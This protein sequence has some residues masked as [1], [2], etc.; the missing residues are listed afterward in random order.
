MT[1]IVPTEDID[2][3]VGV[4]RHPT[5]H[6]GR[7]VSAEQTVYILHSQ[8][9]KDSTPDLR[10]CPYSLSLD[11]GVDLAMGWTEDVPLPLMISD[12]G[13]EAWLVP[14]PIKC[15]FHDLGLPLS[16]PLDVHCTCPPAVT[17]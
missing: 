1:D 8:E 11:D 14:A 12:P 4:P 7:A 13:G 9:C 17:P 10:D 5:Q 6:W 3:I 16:A 2:R 15:P